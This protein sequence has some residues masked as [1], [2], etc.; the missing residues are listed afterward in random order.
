MNTKIEIDTA[1]L[2]R[3]FIKY[4]E[5][6]RRGLAED[7][8]QKAYSIC[9]SAVAITKRANKANIRKELKA[10]SRDFPNAPL[11]AILVNAKQGRFGRRGFYGATMKAKFDELVE[12]RAGA[13]NFLRAGWL[14]A[15]AVLASSIGKS[16]GKNAVQFLSRFGKGGGGGTAAK[17]GINPTAYF[18][19]QSFSRHTSTNNGIKYAEEGLQKAVNQ[20]VRRMGEYVARKQEQRAMESFQNFF[21]V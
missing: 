1:S 17:P 7:I 19:N 20:E 18:W 2:E 9:N 16:P 15:V 14:S 11:G 8:N 12:N 6:S 21:R 4:R 5:I 3:A 13:I 10:S